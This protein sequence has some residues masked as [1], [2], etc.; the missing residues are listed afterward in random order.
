MANSRTPNVRRKQAEKLSTF[1]ARIKFRKG[2]HLR[3]KLGVLFPSFGF[4]LVYDEDALLN[5]P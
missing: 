2:G 3:E 4:L 5:T 1:L